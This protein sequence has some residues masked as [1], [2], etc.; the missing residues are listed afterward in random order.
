MNITLNTNN[1][2]SQYANYNNSVKTSQRVNAKPYA[3]DAVAF[4]GAMDIPKKSKLL[5]PI[6]KLFNKLTDFIAKNYSEKIYTD[7]KSVV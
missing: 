3:K 2:S 1:F 4:S 5:N 7:R 6:N